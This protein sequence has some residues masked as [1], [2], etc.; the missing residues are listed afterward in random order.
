M[1]GVADQSQLTAR[2]VNTSETQT[3]CKQKLL[4]NHSHLVEINLIRLY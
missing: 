1:S 4:I 3:N 2:V